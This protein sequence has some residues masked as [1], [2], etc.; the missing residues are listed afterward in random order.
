MINKILTDLE[1]HKRWMVRYPHSEDLYQIC[2]IGL[3]ETYKDRLLQLSED[4][5]INAVFNRIVRRTVSNKYSEY[6]KMFPNLNLCDL[7]EA[8]NI[9]GGVSSYID[10]DKER[11]SITKGWYEEELLKLYEEFDFNSYELSRQTKIPR[12][13]IDS[14]IKKIKK[15]L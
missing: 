15:R 13:T 9:D 10:I 14:H 1:V 4:K 8:M 5:E 7:E 12:E 3:Y 11:E 2:V 6:N